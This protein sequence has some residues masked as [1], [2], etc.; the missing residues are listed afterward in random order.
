MRVDPVS[1]QPELSTGYV[2]PQN[3]QRIDSDNG[4]ELAVLDVHMG[5]AMLARVHPEDDSSEF[6]DA[7]HA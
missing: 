6:R 2:S 4:P 1:R 5:E 7:R 3:I